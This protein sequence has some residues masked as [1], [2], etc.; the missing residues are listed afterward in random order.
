M[1]RINPRGLSRVNLRVRT[2]QKGDG[3]AMKPLLPLPEPCVLFGVECVPRAQH[4]GAV[5]QRFQ[6][7]FV[8][9]IAGKPKACGKLAIAVPVFADEQRSRP[10]HTPQVITLGDRLIEAPVCGFESTGASPP[11]AV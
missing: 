5:G 3:V 6:A 4:A 11:Y 7:M 9:E 8:F 1:P 10:K 2:A